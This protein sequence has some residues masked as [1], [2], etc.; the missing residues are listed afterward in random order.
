[1]GLQVFGFDC[2]DSLRILADWHLRALYSV[3]FSHLKTLYPGVG[4]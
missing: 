2:R 4:G 1:M 3:Q